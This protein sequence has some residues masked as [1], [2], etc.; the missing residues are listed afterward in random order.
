MDEK[1][2]DKNIQKLLHLTGDTL[3]ENEVK[4]LLRSYGINTTTFYVVQ[5]RKEIEKLDL[6]FPVAL[7]VCSRKILHK[8]DV[9]GVKLNIES[10]DELLLEFD[11]FINRFPNEQFLV[12]EM[13][14]K[15]VE[16]IV[17]LVQDPTFGLCI[18]SGVG[19]IYTELYEDVS[20]RVIPI[21]A[22]D[23]N[24]MVDEIK[25]KTLFEG[26]RNMKADKQ[27][28]IDLLLKVSKIGEELIDYIDQMDLN[29]VFIYENDYCVVD[30][31][32]V[33]RKRGERR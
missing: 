29:P 4:E 26:F 27:E 23:A 21:D 18:M 16:A 22:Y 13:V 28:F 10:I 14:T 25:G 15:G 19:G 1:K 3:A 6:V 11:D 12:D 32:V 30:A 17:G 9:N 5:S 8:T 20:F 7:K 33:L 31:K 2:M 24:E